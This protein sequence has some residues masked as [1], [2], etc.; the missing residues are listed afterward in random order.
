MNHTVCTYDIYKN[1][2]DQLDNKLRRY[3]ERKVADCLMESTFQTPDQGAGWLASGSAGEKLFFRYPYIDNLSNPG[4][5]GDVVQRFT[6]DVV[7]SII[8][9]LNTDT[10]TLSG[11][12]SIKNH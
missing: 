5:G 10:D 12:P 3:G 2:V 11:F 9:N 6:F 1:G 4:G 7:G 8:C